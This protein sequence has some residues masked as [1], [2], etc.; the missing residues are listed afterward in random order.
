MRG[1]LVAT[2]ATL[3]TLAVVP[4]GAETP[5]DAIK[6]RQQVM[7]AMGAHVSAL[8]LV[9]SNRVPHQ[10]HLQAHANA[11]ADLATQAKAVFPPG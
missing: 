11:V 9:Y 4:A 7:A 8:S 5:A 10:A 3:M 6:Y 2:A 1:V